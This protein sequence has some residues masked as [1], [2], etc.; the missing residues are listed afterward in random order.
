MTISYKWLSEYLPVIIEPE[1]LSKILTSVGLEVESLEKYEEIKGGLKGLLVGE[2]LEVEKHPNA[3]KLKLTKV[4]IGKAEPLSIVCGAPN[5]AVGQ[6]VIVAP[7][8]VTIYPVSGEPVTMKTATIRNAESQG[9]ICA[10]DEIGIGNSH[11]GIFVLPNDLKPGLPVADFFN[12]NADWIYEIGL[13]PNRMDAM[14]HWGVARDVCAFLGHHEKKDIKPKIPNTN[15]FKIDNT[16][17]TIDVQVEN[18]A[19][20]PRY[21]GISISN[22]NISESPKW[23][24]QKLK[25]IG[26]RP[27]NN[28]VDITNF[29]LHETGQPLHAF[30]ADTI[31]GKKIIVKNLPA[32][33]PF[34]TLDEKERKLSAEDLIICN[35][36]TGQASANEAMCIAGVFGGMHSGVTNQTKNIFLESACF[37]PVVTRKTSFYHGLRTDAATRFEKGTDISATVNVLK[38]AAIMIKEICGGT[39]SSE[40]TDVYP[41]PKEKVQVILKY[42]YLKK[43]SGKNYHPDTVKGI[44]SALGFEILKEDIDEIRIAVPYHKPDV[45]LPA[46]IVEE[47]LRIDGL[48]NVEI[49]RSISITPSIEK[50]FSKE[51]YKEKVANFLTGLGFNEIMTNS[52]TNAAYF[53]EEELQSMV[54]MMNSLTVDLNILRNS[55]LETALEAVS[56]NLNHKNNSLKLFEF[57]KSY[58][59]SGT[60][61][62]FESER[63]CILITGNTTEQNWNQK[64]RPADFYFLKGILEGILKLLNRKPDCVEISPVEKLDNHIIFRKE[65]RVLAGIGEVHKKTLSKFNIKQPVFFAELY[66]E[67]FIGPASN[68]KTAIKELPRFPSVQRDLALIVP[69]QLHFKEI[70]Q[71]VQNIRLEKLQNLHLFDIF[72]SEKLGAGK[73]SMA[74]SF[75]FLDL[76]KTLTDKEI[77]GWMNRIMTTLEKDLNA[78]IRKQ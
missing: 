66:W 41:N 39:L 13:T 40:I 58:S 25:A 23:L 65:D 28:I 45:T 70:E 74:I 20:C 78:E 42:H 8:G 7:V 72:E 27:I 44:L 29:I 24:Q 35:Q 71:S 77:D 26:V 54:K 43:L 63:L 60:G 53:S 31:T 55:L 5:V 9:M 50:N 36:P 21:S 48:D 17:L 10:E 18:P 16:S 12:P 19:A 1:R 49:P 61:K 15:G 69:H 62:F 34:I 59:T 11:N 32:G 2:V 14:S 37:D 52:I 46:D 6:K 57:G 47:V 68:Q 67:E 56:H 73:K 4:D 33:T 76:E 22:V 38:R 51:L 30:D 75:T 64:L 3:D